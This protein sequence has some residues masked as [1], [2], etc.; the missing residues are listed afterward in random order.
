MLK[1]WPHYADDPLR[2]RNAGPTV[3]LLG[4][5][6]LFLT[7]CALQIFFGSRWIWAGLVVGGGI[8]FAGVIWYGVRNP[9][10]KTDGD[11]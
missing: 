6:T 11:T 8:M 3:L 5:W 9:V 10:A 2:R 1:P 4:G 7:G